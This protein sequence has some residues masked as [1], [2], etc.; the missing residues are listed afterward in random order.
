M[1]DRASPA[2]IATD[3]DSAYPSRERADERCLSPADAG[4][5]LRGAP[6]ERFVVLGDSLAEG[7]GDRVE[8]YGRG[9]WPER[10]ATALRRQQPQL[11]FTNLGQRYLRAREVRERQLEHAVRLKPD[12][13]SVVCGG[14]DALDP[15]LDPTALE[16]E[17]ETLVESLRRIG[18]DVITFT[19][20][21]I[22]QAVE[23]PRGFGEQIHARLDVLAEM[24]TRI[25]T[26]HGT[27][28]VDMRAH[29]ACHH[30]DLYSADRIH[31]STIG[32]AVIASATI[33]SLA[34]HIHGATDR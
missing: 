8:G 26:R 24:T 34:E 23:L 6:W 32:H 7:L 15:E 16:Q 14:N 5:L 27:I 13:A 11:R 22:S 29:P 3:N 17:L 10:V 1:S 2:A 25:A 12:L 20:L 30:A 31:A 9:S 19:L 4:R 28:H 18:S 21:D 33:R